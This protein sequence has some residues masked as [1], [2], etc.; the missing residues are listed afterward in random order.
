[1]FIE[2]FTNG[3]VT[4]DGQDV[5]KSYKAEKVLYD[6]LIN[7]GGFIKKKTKKKKSA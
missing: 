4:I 5:S 6:Y 7:P 2:L 1:M 3:T